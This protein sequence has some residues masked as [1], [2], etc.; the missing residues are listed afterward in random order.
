MGRSGGPVA[1]RRRRHCEAVSPAL[2]FSVAAKSRR[3]DQRRNHHRGKGFVPRKF[4]SP[5]MRVQRTRSSASRRRSPLTRYLLGDLV[6]GG[7]GHRAVLEALL[8]SWR[9]SLASLKAFRSSSVSVARLE[10]ESTAWRRARV[11]KVAVA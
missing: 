4:W 2:E 5:N 10:S 6:V 8:A 7:K 11:E 1:R 3:P 9:G